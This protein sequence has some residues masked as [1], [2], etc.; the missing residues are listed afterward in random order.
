M[1]SQAHAFTKVQVLE[2]KYTWSIENFSFLSKEPGFIVKSLPFTVPGTESNWC[3]KL[4]PGG[5]NPECDEH[6]SVFLKLLKP[7]RAEVMAKFKL[8]L[9]KNNNSVGDS[10]E[11]G[12]YNFTQEEYGFPKVIKRDVLMKPENGLLLDDKLKI[13]CEI[14]MNAGMI[15]TFDNELPS[16]NADKCQVRFI[17]DIHEMYLKRQLS[18]VKLVVD[19]KEFFAHK[20]ILAARSPIFADIFIENSTKN[21]FEIDDVDGDVM[22]EVLRYIYSGKVLVNNFTLVKNVLKAAVEYQFYD[23]N[24]EKI[25][26]ALLITQIDAFNVTELFIFSDDYDLY[27]LQQAAIRYIVS[28]SREVTRTPGYK[29]MVTSHPDLVSQLF[30]ALAP[31]NKLVA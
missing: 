6:M 24:L 14:K 10:L 15:D 29:D 28:N 9:E 3:L 30:C 27:D 25:C 20:V 31:H 23:Y 19:G 26:E 1:M 5:I 12:I 8:Y 11:S 17:N 13:I 2:F 18:D 7:E 22:E 16:Y 4:Y 21:E